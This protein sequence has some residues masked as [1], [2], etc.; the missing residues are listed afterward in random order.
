[1]IR[2]FVSLP[3]PD[4]LRQRVNLLQHLLPLP[5]RVPPENLHLTLAFLGTQPRPLLEDVHDAL[6]AVRAPGFGLALAG[7]GT[8]GEPALRLVHAGVVP[9]AALT[10]LQRK[11]VAAVRGAGLALERRRFQPHVTLSRLDW[12]R[13]GEAERARLSAAIAAHAGFR[14]GPEPVTGFA[15]V[16]SHLGREGAHYEDLAQYPLARP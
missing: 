13:L 10:H 1:M 6:S 16:R 5:Q 4:V 9:C 14:A 12:R 2:A 7:V 15:L 11:V 3:L 8:F